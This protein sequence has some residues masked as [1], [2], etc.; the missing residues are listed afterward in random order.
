MCDALVVHT[1]TKVTV[2]TQLVP[3]LCIELLL[4]HN[5]KLI[6]SFPTNKSLIDGYRTLLYNRSNIYVHFQRETPYKNVR[7]KIRRKRFHG[8]VLQKCNL[9]KL[10]QFKLSSV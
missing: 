8:M 7:D 1:H 2:L 9:R 3:L 4:K 10:S 5:G 6:I